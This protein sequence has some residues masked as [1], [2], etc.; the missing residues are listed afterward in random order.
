MPAYSSC[1]LKSGSKTNIT[2][3]FFPILIILSAFI[4]YF[5]FLFNLFFNF[6]LF[7]VKLVSYL[8]RFEKSIERNKKLEKKLE[9]NYPTRNN[10]VNTMSGF[11]V[12]PILVNKRRKSFRN[13]IELS[14]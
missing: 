12:F 11:I 14:P 10:V 7:L 6:E 4:L 3:V 1:S 9:H 5:L 2:L 13:L 8:I